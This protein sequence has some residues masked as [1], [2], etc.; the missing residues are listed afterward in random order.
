LPFGYGAHVLTSIRGV[1]RSP[2]LFH[3]IL[4]FGQG[5]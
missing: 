1:H 2:T 4:G 3:R 5:F